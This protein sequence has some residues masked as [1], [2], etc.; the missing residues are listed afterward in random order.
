MKGR[1]K[2]TQAGEAAGFKTR[3]RQIAA[4]ALERLG[5]IATEEK[6]APQH[7]IPA[8][9]AVIEFGYGRAATEKTAENGA[10]LGMLD[11]LLGTIDEKAE[12]EE[13]E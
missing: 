6:Y 12:G 5:E 2:S 3:A 13:E 11:E 8:A 4:G 10:A 7:A 9:K 1:E